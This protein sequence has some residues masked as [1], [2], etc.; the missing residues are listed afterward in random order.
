MKV[1]TDDGFKRAENAYAFNEEACRHHVRLRKLRR[2]P[3][4]ELISVSR[5]SLVVST[6]LA[7]RHTLSQ[8]L[9]NFSRK[10]TPFHMTGTVN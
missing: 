4:S 9:D 10:C 5:I 8:H 2:G 3:L 7:L 6:S 1:K